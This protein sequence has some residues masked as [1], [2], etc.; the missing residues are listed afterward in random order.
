MAQHSVLGFHQHTTQGKARD[1]RAFVLTE[2]LIVM[3]MI[4]A[5]IVVLSPAVHFASTAARQSKLDLAS[6]TGKLAQY[7]GH[8]ED[9]SQPILF[10]SGL[11]KGPVSSSLLNTGSWA[12]LLAPSYDEATNLN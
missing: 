8:H 12:P 6:R 2:S 7:R 11:F 5:S 10:S 4:A 3:G 9:S 1:R